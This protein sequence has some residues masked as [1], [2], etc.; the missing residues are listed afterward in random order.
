MN[1]QEKRQYPEIKVHEL[2][3]DEKEFVRAE[4]IRGV[5]TKEIADEVG[6]SWSQVCGVKAAMTRGQ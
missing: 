5:D 3:C 1:A 6:C 4:L 2:S